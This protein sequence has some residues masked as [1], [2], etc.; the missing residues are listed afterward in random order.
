MWGELYLQSK[1]SKLD[2][3]QIWCMIK[4]AMHP[5]VPRS[6]ASRELV[7]TSSSI[8]TGAE[9][10]R[11]AGVE[12]TLTLVTREREVHIL[13]S[14]GTRWRPSSEQTASPYHSVDVS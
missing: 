10:R 6:F 8:L 1:K 9:Y 14:A 3:A 13:G 7:Y 4:T 2:W 12:Y 11:R 5:E